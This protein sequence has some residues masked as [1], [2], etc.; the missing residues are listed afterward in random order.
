MYIIVGKS[1]SSTRAGVL[2]EQSSVQQQYNTSRT[3]I[4][5]HGVHF[6]GLLR[7]WMDANDDLLFLRNHVCSELF[8]HT[9]HTVRSLHVRLHRHILSLCLEIQTVMS[10]E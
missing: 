6:V 3:E 8:Y 4:Y 5:I 9:L 1:D 10:K 7:H 2:E